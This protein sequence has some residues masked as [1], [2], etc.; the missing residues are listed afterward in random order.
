RAVEKG[1]RWFQE[2]EEEAEEGAATKDGGHAREVAEARKELEARVRD[3]ASKAKE[4]QSLGSD[5]REAKEALQRRELEGKAESTR[6]KT[7]LDAEVTRSRSRANDLEAA[8][9]RP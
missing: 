3:L 9:A 2:M 6:L 7:Q 5:V 4:V 8:G 1:E